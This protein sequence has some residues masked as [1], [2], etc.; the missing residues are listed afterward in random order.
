ME[1]A[2]RVRP[3]RRQYSGAR[4]QRIALENG[5]GATEVR[6]HHQLPLPPIP[7]PKVAEGSAIH[8]RSASLEPDRPI[9]V[10]HSG[11]EV[12]GGGG[13]AVVEETN[14]LVISKSCGLRT[15][16]PGPRL[17]S[18]YR[19]RRNSRIP[20]EQNEKHSQNPKGFHRFAN[21]HCQ[22]KSNSIF[23]FFFFFFFLRRDEVR[24]C[25]RSYQCIVEPLPQKSSAAAPSLVTG[26]LVQS[27][28][29]GQDGRE[30]ARLLPA[31]SSSSLA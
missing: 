19:I 26:L 14:S 18:V 16:N 30:S 23:F 2:V 13:G 24:R 7:C 22:Q 31:F 9:H 15:P 27:F 25:H 17:A 8:R 12:A 28:C 1:P 4:R 6:A 11:R 10:H 3:H 5:A 20:D 29:R 21:H